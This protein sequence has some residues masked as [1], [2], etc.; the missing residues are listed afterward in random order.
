MRSKQLSISNLDSVQEEIEEQ[1]IGQSTE[2]IEEVLQMEVSRAKNQQASIIGPGSIS[3]SPTSNNMNSSLNNS[4]VPS[5][6]VKAESE[7]KTRTKNFKVE[8]C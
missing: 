8:L 6:R 7:Q 1:N 3:R 5:V 2:D 4:F